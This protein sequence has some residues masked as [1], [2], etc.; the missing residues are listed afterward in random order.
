[1]TMGYQKPR[2]F[3]NEIKPSDFKNGGEIDF[4]ASYWN[5][6]KQKYGRV[7]LRHL[8]K[9]YYQVYVAYHGLTY[10]KEE[11]VLMTGKLDKCIQLTNSLFDLNDVAIMEGAASEA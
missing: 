3:L 10:E 7:S 4:T 1:M 6:E 5:K 11:E 2:N 8:H 9:D